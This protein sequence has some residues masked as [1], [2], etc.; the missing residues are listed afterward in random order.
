MITRLL[1]TAMLFFAATVLVGCCFAPMAPIEQPDES[2]S[3]QMAVE[4]STADFTEFSVKLKFYEWLGDFDC[5]V[6]E[7]FLPGG[8]VLVEVF[9]MENGQFLRCRIDHHRAEYE[10]PFHGVYVRRMFLY[11]ANV[12]GVDW[13]RNFAHLP[14]NKDGSVVTSIGSTFNEDYQKEHKTIGRVVDEDRSKGF[15]WGIEWTAGKVTVDI[16]EAHRYTAK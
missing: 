14:E 4:S 13:S 6:Q 3:V 9:M 10:A 8:K 2:P 5:L 16:P 15:W 12:E 1:T 11:P 7:V